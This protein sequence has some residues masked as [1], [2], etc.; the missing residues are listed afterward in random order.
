MLQ[1]IRDNAQGIVS[2]ILVSL[3]AFTFV[4][5]GAES[6]FDFSSDTGAPAAVNGEEI[7]LQE[8]VQSA[9]LQR[10][11]VLMNNP[12]LDPVTLDVQAIQANTLE[13]LI[14]EKVLLQYAEGSGM[15]ISEAAVNQ[16]IIAS[17]DFQVEGKFDLQLFE[18]L[19]A[20]IGLTASVYKQTLVKNN[21]VNQMQQG[22]SAS[23]FTLPEQANLVA[24]LDGQTRSFDVL[25]LPFAKQYEA[26]VI[27]SQAIAEHFNS[28]VEQY[29]SPEQVQ[30]QYV[31]LDK[32]D[33][34]SLVTV[35]EDQVKDVYAEAKSQHQSQ[36]EREA[37]HIL[38][39]VDEQ[40][41]E[42]Q[43]LAL[44]QAAHAKLESGVDFATVAQEFSQDSGTAND[45]GSLGPVLAGDFGGQF[46]DTLFD[47]QV[48]AY[49]APVVTQ[50]GVQI[51][52][53]EG[54]VDNSY[55]S[56]AEQEATLRDGLQL[57]GAE[58]LFVTSSET[59]ADIAFSSPDLQELA[60]ELQ[61]TVQTSEWFDRSGANQFGDLAARVASSAFGD[62]VLV[63]GNNS[64]VIEL[65]SDKMMVL[66]MSSHKPAAAQALEEVSDSIRVQ[67]AQQ[68]ALTDLQATAKAFKQQLEE[69]AAPSSIATESGAV[70]Q[71]H[72]NAPR[73]S[74][75]VSP[76]LS[77]AAFK[78]ARPAADASVFG[79]STDFT[80]DVS[81]IRL[82]NVTDASTDDLAPEQRAS[83][84]S[85]LSNMQGQADVIAFEATLNA[86]AE[87]ERF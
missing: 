82:H 67:L 78:L 59:M 54:M 84:N 61:L 40:Q 44:A 56:Y 66:H 18:S 68:Q 13:Q 9:E 41:T 2:K 65:A 64:E 22:V 51:I 19:I 50:F 15:A 72:T 37:A 43:A 11:Q 76:M 23:A 8:L 86:T 26:T 4:I 52:K 79:I 69:G 3:I 39:N 85:A 83:L 20:N 17:K 27:D 60:D 14:N 71:A 21:L 53:L 47:L 48:G 57:Q 5:W 80:G 75:A 28:N 49:S 38:F 46:D 87:V 35:T 32:Q 34:K 73:L 45:A 25:V 31:V 24:A 1:S 77:Q 6:L 70:W 36:E 58:A 12:E 29:Q 63:N 81:V 16:M 55:P 7:S 74:N 33:F 30:V 10:R 62:E 42:D